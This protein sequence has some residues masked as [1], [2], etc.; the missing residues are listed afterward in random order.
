MNNCL[1]CGKE[2]TQTEG[3]RPRK[4]CSDGCRQK[5]WVK[6]QQAKKAELKG[7]K[8]IELPAD[9]IVVTKI[10]IIN[11][12][13]EIEELKTFEQLPEPFKLAAKGIWE[14]NNDTT[15]FKAQEATKTKKPPSTAQ[16]EEKAAVGAENGE[17]GSISRGT[18]EHTDIEPEDRTD[19]INLRIAQIEKDLALPPKYLPKL[20]RSQLERELNQLKFKS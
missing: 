8:F 2:I 7:A 14:L 4:T 19:E 17:S 9:F 11:E 13:G 12:K 3:K 1:N 20:K 5:L 6:V 15:N 18:W 10:G 16:K